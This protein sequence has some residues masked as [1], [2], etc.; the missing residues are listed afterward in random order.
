MSRK[1]TDW[2]KGKLDSFEDKP[3]PADWTAMEQLINAH[4]QLIGKPWYKTLGGIG[5][6]VLVSALVVSGAVWYSNSDSIEEPNLVP[7]VSVT[8][9]RGSE[10]VENIAESSSVENLYST[11]G[12]EADTDPAEGPANSTGSSPEE[13]F[14]S[15]AVSNR[16]E[17]V[18]TSPSVSLAEEAAASPNTLERNTGS[19]SLSANTDALSAPRS[20]GRNIPGTTP[21]S[22]N[23]GR[24]TEPEESLTTLTADMTAEA[25]RESNRE[26]T[27]PGSQT[28]NSH[29]GPGSS[30]SF[31]THDETREAETAEDNRPDESATA[32]NETESDPSVS[33]GAGRTKPAEDNTASSEASAPSVISRPSLSN[34]PVWRISAYADVSF[35]S[36]LSVSKESGMFDRSREVPGLGIEA[37]YAWGGWSLSSGLMWHRE[38]LQITT[39]SQHRQ[40]T[41]NSVEWYEW[42]TVTVTRI[43]SSWVI[44]GINQG[45]WVYDTTITDESRSVLRERQ[46]SSFY[47]SSSYEQRSVLSN[48]VSVPLM[49]G[50]EWKTDRWS[51]GV[52]A[53]PVFTMH[54]ASWFEGDRFIDTRKRLGTDILVRLEA[55]YYISDRWETFVRFGYRTNASVYQNIRR[56]AWAQQGFPITVGLRYTF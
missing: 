28:Y 16:E 12:E 40:N 10:E 41:F 54:S 24:G 18:G 11:G 5:S 29:S 50:K 27:L 25:G 34:A 21:E 49:F 55:G 53:G 46:D 32:S 42:D 9:E 4:P 26:N 44:S 31:A 23:R 51:V 20:A 56:A 39:Q 37:E 45:G 30:D 3:T 47:I 1:L 48:R 19:E 35:R 7:V 17:S 43:D 13:A 33:Q 2:I 38:S 52:Q 14:Y 8:P 22:S 15:V 36:D 6:L